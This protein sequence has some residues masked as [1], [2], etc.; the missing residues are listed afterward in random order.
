MVPLKHLETEVH[1]KMRMNSSLSNKIT[2]TS[3]GN[4]PQIKSIRYSYW[5]TD[6][7]HQCWFFLPFL[8]PQEENR[9]MILVIDCTFILSMP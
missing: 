6:R 2:V 9:G 5:H 8:K 1:L 4:D 7:D 3:S